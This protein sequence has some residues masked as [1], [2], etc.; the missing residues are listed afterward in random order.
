MTSYPSKKESTMSPRDESE[1]DRKMDV[2]TDQLEALILNAMINVLERMNE[3]NEDQMIC[4]T[5][6]TYI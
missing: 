5:T 1:Y 3:R 4:Q 6:I 2:I